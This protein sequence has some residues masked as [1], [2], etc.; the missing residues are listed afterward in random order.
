GNETNAAPAPSSI[1]A[2]TMSNRFIRQW[3]A[4]QSAPFSPLLS[5]LAPVD[6]FYPACPRFR[7][8]HSRKNRRAA[9]RAARHEGHS[10]Y[11]AVP[12]AAISAWAIRLAI[13][14]FTA[15]R[16]KLAPRCIGG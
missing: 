9:L 1:N 13:S 11:W 10:D 16:L 4:F 15:S 14:A 8:V 6:L 3:L 7:A 12:L 5:L 2:V